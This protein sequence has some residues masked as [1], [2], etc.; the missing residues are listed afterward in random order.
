MINAIAD[1]LTSSVWGRSV[2]YTLIA[3]GTYRATAFLLSLASIIAGILVLPKKDWKVY[4]ASSSADNRHWA[5]VTGASDGIGKEYAMQLA[6]RGLNLVLVS[7]TLS[8]LEALSD[9]IAA[10]FKVQVKILDF[11]AAIDNDENY[12]RLEQAIAGLPVL[13][14]VNNVGQSHSIPV[15]FTE[16]P[17][18]ELKSI[19]AINNLATLRVTSAVLPRMR[20]TVCGNTRGL[21][22]TMGSFGG[23]LP[24]PYLATY[25]G[26]KAFLQSW[27]AALAGELAPHHI[28]VE[29]V[30]LYLVTLAMSKVRRTSMTIPSPKQ[31]V[32][33]T[34]DGVG[35]R[36]GL[37]D[38]YGTSTPYWLHALMQFGIENTVG[39]YSKVANSLNRSMHL[40]IR[41][42][43]LK[44][45]SRKAV[46]GE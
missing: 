31:F 35:R 20:E 39:V 10:T 24:T 6:L 38:R 9:E 32:R 19:I 22:L 16:T 12:V 46:K 29:L 14:L 34:L 36:G 21:V 23:L 41:K 28:D 8:K 18:G 13:V 27:L 7:R 30:V 43:A 40:S 17:M 37:Q 3:V 15:P 11:D 4:G 33:A 1:T 25:S 2:L 5:V 44:K 26:S 42:R 45:Q